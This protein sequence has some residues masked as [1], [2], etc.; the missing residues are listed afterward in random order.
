MEK[1]LHY[2][3]LHKLFPP[4]GL[5]TDE[6]LPVDVVD[7]GLP[8]ANAGPDF[9]GA[10]V[11][12]GPTLWAGDVE[13]HLRSSDW[14]RHG[15]DS[16]AAYNRVVL[17]VAERIDAPVTTA[18]GE[19]VPQVA[20]P[21]P[22]EL[23]T[24]YEAL[25]A[26]EGFPPCRSILPHVERPAARA[27]LTALGVERLEEKTQHVVDV[28]RRTGGDWERTFFVVLARAFGFGVNGTA[29]E[30]WALGIEPS[31]VGKHR[32]DALQVEAFFLGRAGLL[33][34]GA[35]ATA[36]DDAYRRRLA[37]EYAFL[38][39]KFGL[40]TMEAARWKFL[41]LR[42]QNFPHVRLAQLADL[43]H[44]RSC[45]LAA[46]LEAPRAADV[47]KLLAA[48]AGGYWETHYVFG[49]ESAPRGKTLSEASLDGL[50]VNAAAPVLFAYGRRHGDEARCERAMEWLEQ[51][52]PER[53]HVVDA[54]AAAGLTADNAAESQALLCLSHRYCERHDCL[55]CRFGAI[56]LRQATTRP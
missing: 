42:P 25:L 14:H 16:D 53:N 11:R 24:H 34:A 6:G 2:V 37:G 4:G 13:L 23:R 41:R 54:W 22:A 27:W 9:A 43:Y 5:T 28:L 32:D 19:R 51:T 45:P 36:H 18:A 39:H 26:E 31:A 47:K 40:E 20:L 49:R 1:L 15:H 3:W 30:E 56:W 50:V 38:S 52:R 35:A 46:V 12:I 17:H 10:K 33:E 7:P 8:N 21:V 44:R 55:R 48:R 29:F